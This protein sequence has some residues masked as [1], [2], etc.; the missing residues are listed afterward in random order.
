M[1]LVDKAIWYIETH[2][3]E[4]LSLEQVAAVVGVSPFTLSR[5]FTTTTGLSLMRYVRLRRL[6]CAARELAAGAPDILSLALA[7][8]YTSH[9]AFTRAFR[10]QFGLTPDAV[11]TRGDVAGLPLLDPLRLETTSMPE[12]S[13]PR[14]VAGKAM[15]VTGIGE[16]YSHADKDGIPAQ[17]QRFGEVL[18]HVSAPVGKASYGVC[19]NGDDEGN[20]DYVCGVEVADFSG[21]PKHFARVRI[22]PY[23]YA[24]FTHRGDVSTLRRTITA[25]WDDW[26]PRSGIALADGPNFER[27]GA[28]FDPTRGTGTIEIWLPVQRPS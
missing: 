4:P 16:R 15:L 24:V 8:G 28:D 25:I 2:F 21:L 23:H 17:W 18:A 22:P 1:S 10:D 7:A 26:L 11:R 9:E 20:F 13:P 6:S 12:L 14:F 3:G 27:Y 19:C 5:A